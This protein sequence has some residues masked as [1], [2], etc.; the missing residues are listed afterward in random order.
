MP[1]FVVLHHRVPPDHDRG[2]HFDFMIEHEG[3]LRT[4]ALDVWPVRDEPVGALQLPDHR[5][6][7]LDY[8]GPISG[9]R[10]EV[11]RV[12]TGTYELLNES[13]GHMQLRLTSDKTTTECRLD[14]SSGQRW[15]MTSSA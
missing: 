4:W 7:Y 6:H 3:R 12:A 2:D 10:G 8:E 5:V 14:Q 11:S 15:M 1:R 13:T 9:G